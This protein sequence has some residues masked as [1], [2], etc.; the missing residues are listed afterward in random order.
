LSLALHYTTQQPT[1]ISSDF[2]KQFTKKTSL[3]QARIAVLPSIDV[4]TLH[5]PLFFNFFIPEALTCY[6]IMSKFSFITMETPKSSY[7][8]VPLSS[9]PFLVLSISFLFFFSYP[10]LAARGVQPDRVYSGT[11]P[12]HPKNRVGNQFSLKPV[13]E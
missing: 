4:L 5:T 3:S 12:A 8:L 1:P 10:C 2:D 7:L 9:V 6:I 13:R 11:G